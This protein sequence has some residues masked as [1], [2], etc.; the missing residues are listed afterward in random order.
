MQS[1]D[2]KWLLNENESIQIVDENSQQNIDHCWGGLFWLTDWFAS[3][4]LKQENSS[5]GNQCT[6]YQR[7]NL[8]FKS[9]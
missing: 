9:P 8:S 5:G 4:D 6:L 7:T 2:K 3:V 1:I